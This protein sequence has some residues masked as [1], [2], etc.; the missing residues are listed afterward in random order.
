MTYSKNKGASAVFYT[1]SND[2]S[3]GPRLRNNLKARQ[4][5]C[6]V[7]FKITLHFV[8]MGNINRPLEYSPKI[9]LGCLR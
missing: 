6:T 2:S 1:Q 4:L 9:I 5:F 7:S 3:K 8:P